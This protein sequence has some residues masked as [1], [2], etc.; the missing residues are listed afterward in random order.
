MKEH[1]AYRHDTQPGNFRAGNG[2]DFLC[3]KGSAGLFTKDAGISSDV[4][5]EGF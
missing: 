1:R 5:Y 2:S 3:A 4:F